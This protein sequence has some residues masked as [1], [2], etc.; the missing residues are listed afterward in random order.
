MQSNKKA[1]KCTQRNEKAVENNMIIIRTVYSCQSNC[2]EK[3]G[4]ESRKVYY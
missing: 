2:C 3:E 1:D 4:D